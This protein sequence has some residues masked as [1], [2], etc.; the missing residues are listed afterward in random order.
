M[1]AADNSETPTGPQLA[2]P[3]DR[4]ASSPVADE[5]NLVPM[6]LA[7][8]VLVLL[9]AIVGVGG[10]I[11]RGLVAG[12]RRAATP[13]EV[14]VNAWLSKVEQDSEN[15]ENHLGLG[16]AYQMDGRYDKALAEYEIVLKANPADTA[17]LYNRGIIYLKLDSGAKGEKS[18]WAVL[19]VEPTHALAAKALGEYYLSQKHYRSL[20]EAVRPSVVAHPEMADLQF[21]MATAYENLGE[22][23][24]AIERY[25]LAL[26]YA[27]D[28]T[29]ARQGLERLGVT[30]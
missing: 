27:P 17:A 15:P 20:I 28:M 25:R 26:K 2:T 12:D 3:A 13:Q 22:K 8:L 1:S 18:L 30:P 21:L 7:M 11:V 29:E 14:Q 9:L 19:D 6:W 24:W 5:Q 16:Y 10:F 4:V 23:D